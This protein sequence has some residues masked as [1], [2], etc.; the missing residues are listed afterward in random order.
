MFIG[1]IVFLLL[2]AQ[3]VFAQQ[4]TPI[5]ADPK[6]TPGDALDV[7]ANDLCVPDYAKEVRNVPAEMKRKVYDEYGV[8]SHGPVFRN[9]FWV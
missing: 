8:I 7:T 5:L 6:L 9:I 2:F 4:P 3:V 1:A